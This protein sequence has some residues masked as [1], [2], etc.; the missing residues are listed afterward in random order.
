MSD[1]LWQETADIAGD[2]LSLYCSSQRVAPL[3]PS[4]T[5]VAM[6]HLAERF[7]RQ[8]QT[9]LYLIGLILWMHRQDPVQSFKRVITMVPGQSLLT[10]DQVIC[11]FII[12]RMVAKDMRS[13]R[14][15]RKLAQAIADYLANEQ[16]D[17]MLE[18]NGWVSARNGQT[19]ARGRTL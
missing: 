14:G 10:W 1:R 5:V 17:W 4:Q 16:K 18:H 2:Y 19:M 12:A 13:Q 6:R 9:A 11:I 15:N 3:P 8:H 7:E